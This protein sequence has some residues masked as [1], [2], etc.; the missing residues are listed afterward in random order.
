MLNFLL[1]KIFT[2]WEQFE[3]WFDFSDLEDEDKTE[4]F[5]QDKMKQDLV[6][7]MHVVLQPLLLRRVK[8]DVEHLLPKKREYILYAPMTKDQTDLYNAIKDKTVDTRQFLENKVFERLTETS[9]TAASSRKPSPARTSSSSSKVQAG[10]SDS[11]DDVP[12]SL[13]VRP[14]FNSAAP[15]NAFQQMMAKKASSGGKS[16]YWGTF[17]QSRFLMSFYSRD[18]ALSW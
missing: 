18:H 6:K 2:N 4:E 11:E 12:L 3:S 13:R 10:D 14:A 16:N 7:K 17:S 5:L 8:A 9:G 15:K 1:P